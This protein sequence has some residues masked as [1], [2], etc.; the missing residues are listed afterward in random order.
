MEN[1]LNLLL[2][3]FTKVRLFWV[4]SLPLLKYIYFLSES[5][6]LYFIYERKYANYIMGWQ[7][8]DGI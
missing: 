5:F 1:L 6:Y 4:V 8:V 7:V 3:K 2:L